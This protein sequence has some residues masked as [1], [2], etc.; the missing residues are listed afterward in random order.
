MQ[1]ELANNSSIAGEISLN[2]ANVL[3]SIFPNVVGNQFGR[4]LLLCKQRRVYTY[5]ERFFVVTAIKNTYPSSLRQ[6]LCTT[7]KEIMAFH[8]LLHRAD[9]RRM[10]PTKPARRATGT[11]TADRISAIPIT[12]AVTSSIAL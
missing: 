5:D 4:E 11:K 6:A 1:K 9:P 8:F 2:A 7:P 10:L 3:E 12:G